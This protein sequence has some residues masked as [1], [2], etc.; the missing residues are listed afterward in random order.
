MRLILVICI[1]RIL[2]EILR[3]SIF[4]LISV[5]NDLME[6]LMMPL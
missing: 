1:G 6:V 3:M 2:W 5:C 4:I